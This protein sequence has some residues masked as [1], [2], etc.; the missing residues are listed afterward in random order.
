M[1]VPDDLLAELRDGR[2]VAGDGVVH[3]VP[4]HRLPA[5]KK[6]EDDFSRSWIWPAIFARVPAEMATNVRSCYS[7]GAPSGPGLPARTF[8]D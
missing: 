2:G 3:A 5:S 6:K 8:R 7:N 1:P 4:A